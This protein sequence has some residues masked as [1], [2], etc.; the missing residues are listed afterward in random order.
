MAQAKTITGSAGSVAAEEVDTS[1]LGEQARPKLLRQALLRYD[2]NQR[3]GTHSTKTRAEVTATGRK[4][5]RQK[6]TGR[7]RA[8]DYS[9]PLWRGG[10]TIF[11]PRPRKYRKS[12]P[13]KARREAL[14]SALLVRFRDGAVAL[15]RDVNWEKPSTKNAA[16]MLRD[17]GMERGAVVVLPS[18]NETLQLSF[19]N[20][21][22]V[23]VVPAQDLNAQH[24]LRREG[25]VLVD[26][27][28]DLLQQRL[29]P[30]PAS[31]EGSSDAH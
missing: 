23:D 11:G 4:P 30:A 12:M 16:Q 14:R 10:G 19:R 18:K 13:V 27:A 7:A 24:I 1:S 3:Q 31:S 6:G 5:F 20:L 29:G 26:N 21:P 22:K 2:D 28:L 15:A 8:G 17:L 9:S 25:L